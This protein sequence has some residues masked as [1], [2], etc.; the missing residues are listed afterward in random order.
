M[1]HAGGTAESLD[2]LAVL[3]ARADRLDDAAALLAAVDELRERTG[4]HRTPLTTRFISEA[5]DAVSS[6]LP[7]AAQAQAR[8]RGTALDVLDLAHEIGGQRLG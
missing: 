3:Q 6:G 7:P 1:H 2:C 8:M 4:I 5:R